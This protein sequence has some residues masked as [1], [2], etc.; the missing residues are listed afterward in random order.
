MP[1]PPQTRAPCGM[2]SL[3]RRS[4]SPGRPRWPHRSIRIA[5]PQVWLACL[6]WLLL[7]AAPVITQC[8]YRADPAGV[9]PGWCQGDAD[10]MP[11]HAI[12][13][14]DMAGGDG[15]LCGYCDLLFHSPMQVV[16]FIVAAMLIGEALPSRAPEYWAAPP[17]PP[18]QHIQ[19]RGPPRPLIR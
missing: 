4:A 17:H 14:S 15:L 9:F 2:A 11:A 18:S 6:A 16:D 1:T 8:L 19:P 7:N 5:A 3:V 10:P 13:P 12:Q